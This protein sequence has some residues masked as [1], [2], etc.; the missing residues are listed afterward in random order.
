MI[1]S[2]KIADGSVIGS[3]VVLPLVIFFINVVDRLVTGAVQQGIL[4]CL[5]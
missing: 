5:G 2:L 1:P 4:R 3:C